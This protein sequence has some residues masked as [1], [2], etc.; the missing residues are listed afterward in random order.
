MGSQE[1]CN[2]LR[3]IFTKHSVA[4]ALEPVPPAIKLDSS[5]LEPEQSNQSDLPTEVAVALEPVPPATKLDSSSL[6]SEQS[7]Q[8]D[9]ATEVAVAL[10]PVPPAT[11]IDSSSLELEQSN[12]S[13]PPTEVPV[14][15]SGSKSGLGISWAASSALRTFLRSST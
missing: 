6:E 11:K 4:V 14:A 13:D 7:N 10:E 5:S 8:S 1:S 12:Q 3:A 15:T 9:P 2:S